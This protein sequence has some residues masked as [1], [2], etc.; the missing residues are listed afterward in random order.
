MVPFLS[1]RIGGGGID[2]EPQSINGT[3][4]KNF[5]RLGIFSI[6]GQTPSLANR[7]GRFLIF[8]QVP[9]GLKPALGAVEASGQSE[10]SPEEFFGA[11]SS[12]PGR[13]GL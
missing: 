8:L 11:F 13:A 4:S 5:L 10:A 1:L 3:F 7:K 2:S 12:Q 9:D 6:N